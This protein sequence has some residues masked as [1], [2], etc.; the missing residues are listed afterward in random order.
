MAVPQSCSVLVIGGGPAGSYASSVLARE[1]IDVVCLEAEK[2]P[3]YHIGESM[4][5]S[6][7]FFLKFID[8]Y[9]KF[10]TYGFR[11]KNGAAFKLNWSRPGH[12]TDFIAAGGP[13]GYSWNVIRSEADEILFRH[14]GEC[15]AK[16][17]DATKVSVIEFEKAAD[18]KANG[19]TNGTNS[20]DGASSLGRPVSATWTA[21]DGSSGTIRFDYL[22]DAS[23]R[24]GIVSTKYL[25]NR[26]FNQGLKN[27]ASWGYW[28]GGG[29]YAPGTHMEGSPYFEALT[30]ASGWCWII[31]LHDGTHSVGV[32]QN[33]EMATAKKR[34]LGSPSSADFYA[35]MVDMAPNVKE[36]LSK[37]ELVSDVKSASDWS[38]TASTYAGP[39]FRLVGDASC[40]IDPFFSSGVHLAL[41]GALSAAAT[42][43]AGLRG[44]CDETTAASWHS[45]RVAESYTRFLLV[46]VGAQKQIRWQEQPVLYDFDEESY[47]RAFELFRPVIQ[48]TADAGPNPKLTQAEISKTIEFGFRAMAQ[49]SPE[50][51][52]ALVRKLKKL[53]A[54]NDSATLEEMEKIKES[55]TADERQVLDTMRA[56]RL[57][58]TEDVHNLDNFTLDVIDGLAPNMERGKLGL[59]KPNKKKPTATVMYD[60]DYLEPESAHFSLNEHSNGVVA[61]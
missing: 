41:T 32:V 28:K 37:A 1:G 48:G 19:D 22:I 33:Q 58:R 55:L 30:D 27:I 25:K 14:A 38:Y 51:K 24:N 4:L 6:M 40:F 59:V 8:A 52:E 56:R 7:R 61:I 17:F 31:P 57:L 43:C 16:I 39:H 47:A 45:K 49:V 60:I 12:Y 50:Q 9:D 21:K 42:I 35:K 3:R 34:E 53:G 23:G 46:V 11:H 13:N 18:P 29:T 20:V 26:K 5:P 44:D 2:F 54:G 15:G 36:L 10:D